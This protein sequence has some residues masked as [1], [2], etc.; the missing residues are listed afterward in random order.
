MFYTSGSREKF[1][2]SVADMDYFEYLAQTKRPWLCRSHAA[3]DTMMEYK[4]YY[5]MIGGSFDGH[6]WTSG[7]TVTITVHDKEHPI[8]K[9]WGEEFTIK[10]E[11][12]EFKNWQP[13]KVRIF[14]ELEHGKDPFAENRIDILSA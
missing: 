9:P 3:T 13:G 8:S 10:D 2:I 4:P 11:I 5:E 12:Y 1:D 6:P 7:S 14:D